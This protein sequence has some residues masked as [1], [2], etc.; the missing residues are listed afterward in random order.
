ML[1]EIAIDEVVTI[2]PLVGLQKINNAIEG[3]VCVVEV[4]QFI[5]LGIVEGYSR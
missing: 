4:S 2:L 5:A 3:S 1:D